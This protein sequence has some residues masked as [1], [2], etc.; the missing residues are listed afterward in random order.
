MH[1]MSKFFVSDTHFLIY[2]QCDS[3]AYMYLHLPYEEV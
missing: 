1:K 3:E 2:L